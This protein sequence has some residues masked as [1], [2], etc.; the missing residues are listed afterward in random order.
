MHFLPK[1]DVLA[2][3]SSCKILCEWASHYIHAFVLNPDAEQIPRQQNGNIDALAIVRRIA[4]RFSQLRK[5]CF[6]SSAQ[7][8]VN[9]DDATVMA[10]A[11]HCF[12]LRDVDICGSN[13]SKHSSITDASII[14]LAN[15][16]SH[17]KRVKLDYC[18]NITDVSIARLLSQCSALTEL[19]IVECNKVSFGMQ[20]ML[21][22]VT[23][24]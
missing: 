23:L 8:A 21:R 11:T 1:G 16:C 10:L 4:P 5:V 18:V 2:C 7:S 13:A 14:A 15:G 3:S 17:L 9:I 22:Y 24:L 20:F 12:E 19:S 6:R